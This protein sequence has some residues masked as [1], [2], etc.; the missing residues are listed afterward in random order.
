[1]TGLSFLIQLSRRQPKTH[2]KLTDPGEFLKLEQTTRH[3]AGLNKF[4]NFVF[5][6]FGPGNMNEVWQRK[7]KDVR[8]KLVLFNIF[9]SYLFK[10]SSS[11]FF[12]CELLQE[13]KGTL[14]NR[15]VFFMR[16]LSQ[17]FQS[18]FRSLPSLR[19]VGIR[20]IA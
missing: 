20:S 9:F 2:Y 10:S 15:S 18:D 3:K 17:Y 6:H 11:L 14:K 5:I 4:F 19:A 13:V 1:M 8:C 16:Y 7:Y 12:I